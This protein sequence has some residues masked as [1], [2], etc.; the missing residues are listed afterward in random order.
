MLRRR[1]RIIKKRHW[2]RVFRLTTCAG[3]L[4]ARQ[5]PDR[6]IT[7]DF[8]ADSLRPVPVAPIF[9]AA[10]GV[11]PLAVARGRLDLLAELDSAQ[12]VR[13]LAPDLAALAVL[14][15]RGVIVAVSTYASAMAGS[16]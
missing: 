4:G 14:D 12:T 13:G 6:R 7:L 15:V 11:T 1:Y 3:M 9:A 8:P 5:E 16:T 2:F 10:L